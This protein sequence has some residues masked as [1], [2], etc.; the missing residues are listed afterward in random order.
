MR[1]NDEARKRLWDIAAAGRAILNWTGKAESDEYANSQLL[2]AAVERQLIII[3]EALRAAV[4]A[5]TKL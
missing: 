5:E 2:R 3:G 4:L 1:L